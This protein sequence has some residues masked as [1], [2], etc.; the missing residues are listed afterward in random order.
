ME[1]AAG[2]PA[3]VTWADSPHAFSSLGTPESSAE[4]GLSSQEGAFYYQKRLEFPAYGDN[5]KQTELPLKPS[6]PQ[7]KPPLLSALEGAPLPLP[8]WAHHGSYPIATQSVYRD[9]CSHLILGR[10]SRPP[11]GSAHTCVCRAQCTASPTRRARH[12][13]VD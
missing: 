6:P 4:G 3:W 12:V 8:S 7:T 9:L 10:L 13:L 2:S 5:K 11:V 1:A